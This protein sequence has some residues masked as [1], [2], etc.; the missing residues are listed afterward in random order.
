MTDILD[1]SGGSSDSA[2]PK[3]RR[4]SSG[5]ASPDQKSRIRRWLIWGGV[6]LVGLAVMTGSLVYTERSDFCKSCHEMTPYY[7]A[8]QASGHVS[9]AECV[10]CHVNPGVIAHLA[11]KPIALK[12][13]YNHFTKDNR[14]PNYGV[15]VPDSRCVGCHPKVDKKIGTRFSHVL[16][17]KNARCQECHATAGHEVSLASLS[18][19][20]ILK[21]GAGMPPV[22]TGVT[23]SVAPGHKTVVCQKCH[24]QAKMKCSLCHQAPHDKKGECSDCHTTSGAFIFVHPV[25]KADCGSCHK[26]PAK[27]PATTAACSNC[28]AAGGKSWAFAH[29]AGADCAKCHKAPAKHY[30]TGCSSCHSVKVP[31]AQ[32]RFRHPGGTGEHSYRSFA[33]TKCHPRSYAAVSCTCHGGRAPRGD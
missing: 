11:H 23:P 9:K 24:D 19:A 2:P 17:Q 27:H 18:A 13:L 33:C 15:E 10:D 12:E 31:F 29:P 22:P 16:H 32:A 30:G 3:R 4:F 26:K 25:S 14:F 21:T 6:A 28:H 8:W 7:S 5:A 20:G 1:T